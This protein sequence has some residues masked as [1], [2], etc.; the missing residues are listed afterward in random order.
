M[1]CQLLQAQHPVVI[2]LS[3]TDDL[4][5]IEFYDVLEDEE[6]FMWFSANNG[7]YRY[8]GRTFVKYDHPQ[9]KGLSVFNLKLDQEGRVWCVNL[10]GQLMYA[11]KDAL[12]IFK[13]I[14]EEINYLTPDIVLTDKK[15]YAF[16][17][18][19][20]LAIDAA[21]KT[22]TTLFTSKERIGAPHLK[23]GKVWF[24]CAN[25]LYAIDS[26]KLTPVLEKNNSFGDFSKEIRDSYFFE[27][28]GDL[29][30]IKYFGTYSIYRIEVDQKK[31][32]PVDIPEIITKT[33]IVSVHFF[34]RQFWFA[35]SNGLFIC[36]YQ[37]NKFQ[38]NYHLLQDQF[39]TK[40]Q[41]DVQSNYWLTTIDDGL[42]VIPNFH[43]KKIAFPSALGRISTTAKK[44]NNQL[45]IGGGSGSVYSYDHSN[46]DFSLISSDV[47]RKVQFIAPLIDDDC[48]LTNYSDGTFISCDDHSQ[49]LNLKGLVAIKS[50]S[51]LPDNRMLVG[52]YSTAKVIKK[53]E[54][55]QFEHDL[56]LR[57]KR[58]KITFYD[59]YLAYSYV[60]YIDA[61]YQ[62]DASFH[63]KE[64]KFKNQPILALDIA[65][66]ADSIIW[67]ATSK[68]GIL[69]L[70]EDSIQYQYNMED[71]LFS[72]TIYHLLS[73]HKDL[74]ITT[75][76]GI[77]KINTINGEIT[78][79]NQSDGIP[80]Y[81]IS[82]IQ[83]LNNDLVF[84]TNQGL[85][86]L[87]KHRVSKKE[88]IPA[89]YFTNIKVENRDTV[90][91]SAYV[92]AHDQN[93]ISFSFFSNGFRSI[94]NISYEYRLKPSLVQWKEVA[95]GATNVEFNALSPGKYS[96]EVRAVNRKSRTYSQ[97][98]TINIHILKPVW[99]QTWFVF[100]VLS[101]IALVTY[102][103]IN[104]RIRNKEAQQRI[105]LKQ[106]EQEKALIAM[107]LE[108]LRSQMNP[109]F[110][111]NALTAIQEYIVLNEK[112]LASEYLVKFSRLIRMYL[113]HSREETIPIK[114]E[115][116]ALKIY[117]MLEKERF[118][119][120][121]SIDIN[122][123]DALENATD[124]VPSLFIQPYV[125]NA[126]KHGLLHRKGKRC[127]YISFQKKNHCIHCLIKDNGVGR[128]RSQEIQKNKKSKHQSFAM[129]ANQTRLDLINRDAVY[130]IDVSI[131]DL[132][133]GSE[134]AGT[135]VHIRIP[136][137]YKN[138]HTTR[139]F[140]N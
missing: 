73:D 119:D 121:I 123:D 118:E 62:Y 90:I 25:S 9:K 130:P 1:F 91:A 86:S 103:F 2:D 133:Q 24:N 29:F 76:K 95:K 31:I 45:L 109:H 49:A 53:N 124:A 13:E 18:T 114:K 112:E 33:R 135:T 115:I 98:K 116:E 30:L 108:N 71:G 10:A 5:D 58:A 83:L 67:I 139:H 22:S 107:N 78:S 70:K 111:F 15:I 66:T 61:F 131:E 63:P 81:F 55:S 69:G 7:L 134:A 128:K 110:I 11:E 74:W 28:D 102:Y 54:G 106:L 41:Q 44:T 89:L 43:L 138:N 57:K 64:I 127:L 104:R 126:I 40:I 17:F 38:L 120:D 32:I 27:G 12:H 79:L 125:E 77:Q 51:L 129:N 35:T 96:F 84:T 101:L 48:L 137:T 99:K 94:E 75:D 85:F 92:L 39:I 100:F 136:N 82:S 60:G 37:D 72:N 46:S 14:G 97:N 50:A 87:N 20:V 16:T 80:N 117:L 36:Q 113:E 56:L 23:N 42:L 19:K 4:P 52:N 6:G 68:E 122:I 3:E 26:E 65:R 88:N 140:L 105:Q 47:K 93:S 8:D 34:D 21:T 132:Y 59:D